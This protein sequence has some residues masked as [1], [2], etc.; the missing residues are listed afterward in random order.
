VWECTSEWL[1]LGGKNIKKIFRFDW[2]S[3]MCMCLWVSQLLC[4]LTTCTRQFNV[5]TEMGA[6]ESKVRLH[7][8]KHV[9]VWRGQ[10]CTATVSFQLIQEK[11]LDWNHFQNLRISYE[12]IQRSSNTI[13]KFFQNSEIFPNFF[14]FVFQKSKKNFKPIWNFFKHHKNL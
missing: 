4:S 10:H 13:R 12:P 6:E 9:G 3:G 14:R 2:V 5:P 11:C 8:L 7:K 1:K